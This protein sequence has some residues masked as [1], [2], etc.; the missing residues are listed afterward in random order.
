MKR[1]S[2][3]ILC[4][5][6]WSCSTVSIRTDGAREATRTPDYDKR[7]TYWWWGFKGEH[8][9]NVRE[10]CNGKGVEQIQAVHSI[11]DSAGILFTLGIYAPRTARIWCKESTQ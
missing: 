10:V 11:I 3:L 9:I 7:H 4:V 1:F 5:C 2:L 8:W 6:L